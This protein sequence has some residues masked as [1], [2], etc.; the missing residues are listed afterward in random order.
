VVG[1]AERFGNAR[2]EAGADIFGVGVLLTDVSVGSI[3]VGGTPIRDALISRSV[4]ARRHERK[5]AGGDNEG[6]AH[7]GALSVRPP[8][9]ANTHEKDGSSIDL[10][11]SGSLI[12][13]LA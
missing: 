8:I 2:T 1:D 6:N 9:T 13:Q 7:S 10:V 11:Q 5:S 3:C 12:Q 4:T